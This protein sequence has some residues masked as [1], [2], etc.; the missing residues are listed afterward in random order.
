MKTKERILIVILQARLRIKYDGDEMY[1]PKNIKA[2]KWYRVIGYEGRRVQ[3]SF[4]GKKYEKTELDF[5]VIG[6][7][8]KVVQIP[9][10]NCS[11]LEVDIKDES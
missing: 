5:L 11:V 4:D 7:N 1:C 10:F 8:Y 3:K 2:G 9:E 6:D